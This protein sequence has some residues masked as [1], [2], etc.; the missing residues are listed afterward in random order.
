[1]YNIQRAIFSLKDIK[2]FW[3]GTITEAMAYLG[4][5]PVRCKI[6]VNN[7]LLQK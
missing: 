1:M 7:K 2:K 5:D 6:I 4:Q 3:N